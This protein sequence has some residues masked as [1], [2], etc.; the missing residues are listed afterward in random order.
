MKFSPFGRFLPPPHTPSWRTRQVSYWIRSAAV[1]NFS[2]GFPPFERP[3]LSISRPS[4]SLSF[5]VVFVFV[6]SPSFFCFGF[7]YHP[8]FLFLSLSLSSS[9]SFLL[10]CSIVLLCGCLLPSCYFFRLCTPSNVLSHRREPF[11]RLSSPCLFSAAVILV[12]F[13][14]PAKELFIRLPSS[15]P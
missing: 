13:L 9:S 12:S 2:W 8:F 5:V 7:P 6:F 15:F 11:Y 4:S 10:L 14:V 1:V 3:F